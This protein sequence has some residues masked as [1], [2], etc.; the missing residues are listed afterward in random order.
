MS[1]DIYFNSEVIGMNLSQGELNQW[2]LDLDSELKG[3]ERDR[4]RGCFGTHPKANFEEF[5]YKNL[6]NQLELIFSL[7]SL[8]S[9]KKLI[10]QHGEDVI[11]IVENDF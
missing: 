11:F 2:V 6:K 1:Y 10:V 9:L 5:I 3:E 7:E 4:F 8:H